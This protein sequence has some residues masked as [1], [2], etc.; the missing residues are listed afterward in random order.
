M[1]KLVRFVLIAV[2]CLLLGI[3]G[4][5]VRVRMNPEPRKR[6]DVFVPDKA[7]SKAE[8]VTPDGG[9]VQGSSYRKRVS[10]FGPFKPY[11][12][13]EAVTPDG[14]MVQGSSQTITADKYA[15]LIGVTTYDSS[16]IS[17]RRLNY[18][19][20]DAKAVADLLKQGGYSVKE[21]LG[22]NA[23]KAAIEAALTTFS[24]EGGANG[25]VLVGLFGHGVQYDERA[26]FWLCAK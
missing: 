20:N 14:G 16:M 24:K 17:D 13:A 19:E 1:I 3:L 5:M 8:A 25:A 26:Y 6:V 4:Y 23:T 21:L 12:K 7:Y 22:E 11:S 2:A 15:L 9:L 18:P 10:V